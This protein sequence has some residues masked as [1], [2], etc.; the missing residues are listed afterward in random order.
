MKLLCVVYRMHLFTHHLLLV[1]VVVEDIVVQ[2][3]SLARVDNAL[4]LVAGN[5]P[6]KLLEQAMR[7][8]AHY[9]I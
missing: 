9:C 3:P 6:L 1:R 8:L 4:R 5:L 2:T 7:Q